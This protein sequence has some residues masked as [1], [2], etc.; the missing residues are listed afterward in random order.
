MGEMEPNPYRSP[1]NPAEGK[2]QSRLLA[3]IRDTLLLI[4]TAFL[5]AVVIVVG[6]LIFA[7][8]FLARGSLPN[9]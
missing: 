3:V 7:F 8:T 2:Q 4:L 6:F 1:V 5:V 9:S